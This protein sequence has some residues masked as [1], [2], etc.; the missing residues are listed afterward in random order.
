MDKD[1]LFLE[2]R[3][4]SFKSSWKIIISWKIDKLFSALVKITNTEKV[5]IHPKVN[6][7]SIQHR[8][9]EFLYW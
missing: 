2:K 4:G 5:K 7:E 6:E 3:Q 1:L 9:R 8:S